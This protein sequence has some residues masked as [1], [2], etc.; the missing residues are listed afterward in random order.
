MEKPRGK[1]A[2]VQAVMDAA[3][4]LIAERGVKSVGLRDVAKV[5]NVNHGLI[6]RHFGTKEGLI[7][8]ISDSLLRMFLE[9]A[10]ERP[11]DS[12]H[13]LWETVQENRMAVRAFARI[14]EETGPVGA[15]DILN[16]DFLGEVVDWLRTGLRI[17]TSAD[18]SVSHLSVYLLA[19]LFFG[20]ETFGCYLQAA[21][22]LTDEG[23]VALRE[24]AVRLVLRA[25]PALPG[26]A[27]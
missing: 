8:Q 11:R 5:A 23:F 6:T 14:I 22:G 3:I 9:G 21:F 16:R 10:K 19:V 13:P 2:V 4:P 18:P 17:D 1:A 20:G 15:S 7:R 27:P 26:E 25:L 12:L 24:Q